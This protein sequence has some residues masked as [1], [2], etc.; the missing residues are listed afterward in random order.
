MSVERNVP[1]DSKEFESKPLF[2]MTI[3][4]FLLLIPAAGVVLLVFFG[5]QSIITF[6]PVRLFLAVL[7]GLPIALFGWLKPYGQPLE[8]FL[9]SAFV[10][11][12]KSPVKRPYKIK[13]KELED[14]SDCGLTH[15][16]KYHSI[17]K[18]SRKPIEKPVSKN[19][20]LK[21]YK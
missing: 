13:Y 6:F 12:V 15:S 8:K 17:P 3:R 21:K 4:Q 7:L 1:K 5:L 16:R 14:N 2:G 11:N 10:S 18:K 20:N 19:Q 9:A